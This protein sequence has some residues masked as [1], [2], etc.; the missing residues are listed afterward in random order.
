MAPSVQ[1]TITIK[2]Y[3]RI[4][5]TSRSQ[6]SNLRNLQKKRM[7]SIS[8]KIV[9]GNQYISGIYKILNILNIFYE[10]NL[11]DVVPP[12]AGKIYMITKVKNML[13]N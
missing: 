10:D 2:R 4:K 11:P 9:M 6:Q 3:P 13:R 5:Y 8:S 7:G 1:H 12:D